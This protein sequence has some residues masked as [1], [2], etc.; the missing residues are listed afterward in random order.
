MP[1]VA[2]DVT[3]LPRLMG[4]VAFYLVELTAALGRVPSPHEYSLVVRRDQA[5][6]WRRA[7]GAVRLIPVDLPSRPA[8]LLWE[9]ARLPG[10][11]RRHSI[12][13]L[14]SPHYTRPLLQLR[15]ASL[16]GIMDMT[17]FLM[18]HYH[19]YAKRLFFRSMI[20]ASVRKAQRFI[21]ISESTKTDMRR[22]LEIEPER[23][24][25]TPLAVSAAYRPDVAVDAREAVRTR[26]QLPN[27]YLLYV[28]RLEPRKNLP[29]LLDAYEAV[30]RLRPNTPPL[31]L[32]GAK[33]WHSSELDGRLEKLGIR[34]RSLGYVPEQ[35]LPALYCGARVFIYPSFYEGFGIPVLEALACGVPTITSNI[36]SMP[37]VAGDAAELVDPHSPG[38]L[39]D[40]LHRLLTDDGRC[41]ELR[42]RGLRRA[43]EFSWDRT[44]RLTVESY[45]RT[46]AEWHQTQ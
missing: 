43:A 25:V 26:Y 10:L 42:R 40:S 29:G 9:Q 14:H 18:P 38:A 11:L 46:F 27:E 4:G 39:A 23:I 28:G 17:F 41:A 2:I 34:V 3:S 31:V 35:D 13:V 1:H 6:D 32:A 7:N 36:S 15:C 22:C 37:E 8:R 21:A 44:A 33:G 5:E 12:D 19:T 24:D 20:R 45:D 30:C 16:V